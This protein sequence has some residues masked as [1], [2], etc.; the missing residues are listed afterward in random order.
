M[1]RMATFPPDIDGLRSWFT[2]HAVEW[3]DERAYRFAIEEVGRVI[4]IVDLTKGSDGEFELGYWL[5]QSSWGRGLAS[6][7]AEAI[8]TFGLDPL[9]LKTIRSG[10]AIDNPASG[11]ILKNLGFRH[12]DNVVVHSRSRGTDIMQSRYV[13][14]ISPRRT[15]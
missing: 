12:I 15:A 4:G 14:N 5:E 1:L 9:G 11:H 7:A 3:L 6:E 13:L 10:H 2:S 8:V